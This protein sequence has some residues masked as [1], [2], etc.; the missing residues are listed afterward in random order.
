MVTVV[1]LRDRTPCSASM[2]VRRCCFVI[3]HLRPTSNLQKSLVRQPKLRPDLLH[4]SRHCWGAAAEP[5]LTAADSQTVADVYLSPIDLHD[6][7]T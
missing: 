2:S 3:V 1:Y 6:E 7:A 5:L 4:R